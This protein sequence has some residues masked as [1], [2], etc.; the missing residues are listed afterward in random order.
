MRLESGRQQQR[1]KPKPNRVVLFFGSVIYSTQQSMIE[2]E[3]EQK[4]FDQVFDLAIFNFKNLSI[5]FVNCF[6]ISSAAFWHPKCPKETKTTRKFSD[7]D[8]VKEM[9]LRMLC[10]YQGTCWYFVFDLLLRAQTALGTWENNK[11]ETSGNQ[12]PGMY[13]FCALEKSECGINKFQSA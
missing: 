8:R 3:Q 13:T 5:G 11:P 7:Y 10:N 12:L 4:M 6:V 9:F 2:E 1:T